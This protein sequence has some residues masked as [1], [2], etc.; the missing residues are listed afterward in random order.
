MAIRYASFDMPSVFNA[1]GLAF[2]CAYFYR[3][4]DDKEDHD[5]RHLVSV[6]G[7]LCLQLGAVL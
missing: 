6:R 7:R 4:K 2:L 5:F 1:A 3:L